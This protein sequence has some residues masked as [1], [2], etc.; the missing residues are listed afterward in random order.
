MST[1]GTIGQ[2]VVNTDRLLEHAMLRIGMTGPK[3]TPKIVQ[4]AEENLF[5]LLLNLSSRGINLWLVQKLLVGLFP[6]QPTYVLPPGTI[7]VL[8]DSVMYSQST[9]PASSFVN[10]GT[11]T[12]CTQNSA[13]SIVRYGFMPS[14]TFT[15]QLTLTL[16]LGVV[17]AILPSQD[18]VA[19]Q[20]Y[21]QDMVASATTATMTLTTNG[22]SMAL[23]QFV[24][25]TSQFDQKISAFNRGEYAQQPNKYFPGWPSTN[26]WVEKLVNP[27]IT[28]WP[29]TP[30]SFDQMTLWV[31]RQIQDVGTLT[32]ELEIPNRW[33]DPTIWMLARRL[34]FEVEGVDPNR[35]T[36]I[37]AECDKI[38][39]DGETGESDRMPQYY[40]PQIRG[41]TR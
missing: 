23:S 35:I 41:Y 20:W 3:L 28:L 11:S 14:A 37:Q 16:D 32:Q 34:C 5:F 13:A 39:F 10:Q 22:A 40:R 26:F 31:N 12:V 8:P 2:T 7:D 24:L 1:S 33:F 36:M 19:G 30:N 21:W 6:G 17:S 29:L 27:Q 25:S 18:W 38:V 15:G 9:I 4:L